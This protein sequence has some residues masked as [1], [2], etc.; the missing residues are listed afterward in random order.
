MHFILILVALLSGGGEAAT[1]EDSASGASSAGL[2]A[3]PQ[4]PTG[5]FTTATEVRPIL[6]ATRGNWVAVREYGGRDLVY[7]TH[8]LSW[9]CGLVQLDYAINGGALTSFPLPACHE[10]LPTPNALLE[11][12][13]A[14]YLG[15][16]L[17]SVQSLEV[18]L[19]YDDLG[20]DQAG[21]E[22]RAVLIP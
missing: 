13:G 1:P 22:R 15:F 11:G 6:Q 20:T 16:A 17:G 21:F 8:L 5:R 19:T 4:A 18:R 2:V 10:D 3:E 9:R 12:D 7:F 14:P